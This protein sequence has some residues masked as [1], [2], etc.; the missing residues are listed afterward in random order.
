MNKIKILIQGYAYQG[1]NGNFFASP[2]TTLIYHNYKRILVDPGTNSKKLLEELAKENLTPNDIDILY[3]THYHPDHFLNIKLFPSLP[4]V[5]G[6]MVWKEDEE[7]IIEDGKIPGTEIQILL[8]P[9]HTAEHSSLLVPTDDLGLVCIAQDVF[10]W[11]DGKQKTDNVEE[12]INYE[13]PFASDFE[14]LKKSRKLVLEKADWIIPGH[15]EMFK[16]PSK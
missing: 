7:I 14:A 1:E 5:D 16:N 12:M 15:G 8:T 3:L 6:S 9:G 10:W 13:D 4:L 11:E 2:T